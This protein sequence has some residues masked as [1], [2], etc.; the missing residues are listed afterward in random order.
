M[1]YYVNL[2]LSWLH[3][4][5]DWLGFFVSRS[6]NPELGFDEFSLGLPPAWHYEHAL[7]LKDAGL[8]CAAHLPFF[9]PL[10]G[11]GPQESRRAGVEVL[12]KAAGIAA[13]Y[14]ADHLI[15]HPSFFAHSDAD[16]NGATGGGIGPQPSKAW[17]KNSLEGWQDVLSVTDA[18]LYLENT[19]DTGPEAVLALLDEL[20]RGDYHA[21]IGLCFDLGHWYSFAQGCDR[22][23]LQEWLDEIAPHLKHLHLHDNA[24]HGDQ[25]LGLGRGRIPLDN[26]FRSLGRRGLK[27]GFTLEPHNLDSLEHS[28]AWLA[29]HAGDYPLFE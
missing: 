23:N 28:L 18:A 10:L 4:D 5:G 3:T 12:K 8:T 13:I 2:P 29:A 26:F 9:G 16:G 24:G 14:A 15:G 20:A 11:R 17:L 1:R 19:Y 22:D 6:L 27:P 21:Q 25:H 7:R